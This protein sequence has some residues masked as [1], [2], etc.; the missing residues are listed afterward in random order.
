MWR[1]NFLADADG[2]NHSESDEVVVTDTLAEDTLLNF[3]SEKALK[4]AGG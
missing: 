1:V 4:Q 3:T 2:Y